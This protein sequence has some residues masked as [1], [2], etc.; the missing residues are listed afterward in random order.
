MAESK[1][2]LCADALRHRVLSMALAP[3]EAL[4]EAAVSAEF[5]VSRTPLREVF[6]VLAGEGYLSIHANK[7][8]QVSPMN[9]TVMRTFFQTAP[10]IYASTAR[11]AAEN[12]STEQLDTLR[13]VQDRFR[14]AVAREDAADMALSNHRFHETIGA[15]AENSYLTPSLRRLLI[16]HTRISQVF[17]R[18]TSSA[19]AGAIQD[20]CTQHDVMIEAIDC[21]APAVIVELT[22]KHWDLTRNSMER[23]V[24]PDPLPI[25][26]PGIENRET[27]NAV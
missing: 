5:G 6:Q 13:A 14:S 4:D 20:A 1:K 17:Y 8:A 7:G 18:P 15:M 27:R 22:M 2:N 26:L 24:R 23:Y 21:Q 3:G 19:E 16:D 9:V 10:L 25:D 11:Q 12:R